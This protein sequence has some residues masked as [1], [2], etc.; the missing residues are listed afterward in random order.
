M[1]KIKEIGIFSIG[2]SNVTLAE[3]YFG[4]YNS[5][6]IQENLHNISTFKRN[7]TIYS[8]SNDSAELFGKTK[9]KLKESG[10]IIEDFDILIASIAIANDCI[11]VTN[12][13]R[14]FERIDSIQ[15]ENWIAK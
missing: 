4:A 8:D 2:I 10:C 1:D 6:H 14:H 9:A 12:N 15:L 3:L 7:L 13:V 11:L 5:K